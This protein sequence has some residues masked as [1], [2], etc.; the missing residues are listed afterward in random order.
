VNGAIRAGF[1]FGASLL[2][3]TL[4]CNLPLAANQ[5]KDA[6]GELNAL[7]RATYTFKPS[8]LSAAERDAK[9][10]ALD[11]VWNTAKSNPSELLP[12]LRTALQ[13]PAADPWFRF[14]GVNLLVQLDPSPASKAMQVRY[15]TDVDLDDVD[16]RYWVQTLARLGAEGYDVSASAARWLTYP[17]A[18]YWLPEHGLYRVTRSNGALYLY[19]S[20]DESQATPALFKIVSN[21]DH[22]GREDALWILMN[23]ATPEALRLL[24]KVDSRGF[25]SQAQRSLGALLTQPVLLRSRPGKPQVSREE[26]LMAFRAILRG[27][28]SAFQVLVERVP[29]G[30]KDAVAVL[31][32]ED[33]P[34]LRQVRRLRIAHANQHAI[35]YYNDFSAIL[36]A[37]TWKPELVK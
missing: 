27:D 5:R 3:T 36:M 12:C 35:E 29:D 4:V 7:I 14:D 28:W 15:F 11:R 16:L 25:S 23:Q 10:K 32:P 34:P 1:I 9:S 6:C 21:P 37:L 17:K 26:Y 19:G 13:D 24:K 31:K 18:E 33:L 2:V 30:E 22:P 20:M 8:R